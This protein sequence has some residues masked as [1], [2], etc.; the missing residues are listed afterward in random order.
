MNLVKPLTLGKGLSSSS[1]ALFTS[2]SSGMFL[3]IA[4]L[5]GNKMLKVSSVQI[6]QFYDHGDQNNP[7]EVHVPNIY[8]VTSNKNSKHD[9]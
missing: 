8:H 9:P 3:S 4:P 6:L 5:I 2:E 7:N 1:K